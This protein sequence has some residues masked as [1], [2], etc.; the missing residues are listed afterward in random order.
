MLPIRARRDEGAETVGNRDHTRLDGD[1]LAA[2]PV[3]VPVPVPPFVVVADSHGQPGQ[4]GDAVHDARGDVRMQLDDLP[5][6]RS[7]RARLQQHPL[8]DPELPDVP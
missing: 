1:L 7:E 6:V 2:E 3:G 5:L 4:P 8:A